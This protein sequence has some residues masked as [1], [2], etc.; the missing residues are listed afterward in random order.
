L[1]GR[2]YRRAGSRLRGDDPGCAGGFAEARAASAAQA[3]GRSPQRNPET[4]LAGPAPAPL[5]RAET[6]YRYQIMLRTR[7]MRAVSRRLAQITQSL[8]LPEDVALTVDIDPV[9]LM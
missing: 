2:G 4:I 7:R 8:A 1:V 5:L 3:R 9:D 6:C